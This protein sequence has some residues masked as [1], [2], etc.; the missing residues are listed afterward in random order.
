VLVPADLVFTGLVLAFSA[1]F[2]AACYSAYHRWNSRGRFTSDT[3]YHYARAELGLKA[4]M[5][6]GAFFFVLLAVLGIS[7]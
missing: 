4:F 3:L 5:I 1:G 7:H 6:S 2:F